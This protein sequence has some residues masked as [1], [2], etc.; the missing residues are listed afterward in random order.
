[1]IA[2]FWSVTAGLSRAATL[3]EKHAADAKSTDITGET[4]GQKRRL[5][6]RIRALI[7]DAERH[8]I[9][10]S[11]PSANRHDPLA[12]SAQTSLVSALQLIEESDV[13]AWLVQLAASRNVVACLDYATSLEA[14]YRSHLGLLGLNAKLSAA[15]RV[16]FLAHELAH[17]PQHPRYSNNRRFSP[18]DMLLLQR[19]REAAAEATATR[20]LWQMRERGFIEPWEE[21]LKTAYHDIAEAFEITMAGGHGTV[22]ELWAARSAFHRWFEADWR[23]EIYDDLMLKTLARIADDPIGLIPASR[24]LSDHFLRG[25]ADY[26]GQGFLL[27]GDGLALIQSFRGRALPAG[28]QIRLDAILAESGRSRNDHELAPL[29]GETLSAVSPKPTTIGKDR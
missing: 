18:G 19:A 24:H 14:H 7:P 6:D 2:V 22:Q 17:V 4:S 5:D 11:E 3:P 26:A 27:G 23:L 13:G 16:V 12:T 20:V 8:C 10:I 1:M 9:W 25:V 28:G 21:K 15:G 29:S